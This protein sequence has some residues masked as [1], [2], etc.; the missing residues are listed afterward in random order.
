MKRA[1]I[2]GATGLV[3]RHL[4]EI[5]I[6]SSEYEKVTLLVRRPLDISS[7]KLEQIIYDYRNPADTEIPGD[8]FFCCLGTTIKKAGSPEVFREV[9]FNYITD[10][11][12]TACERGGE[13]FLFISAMGADKNSKIFYNRVKGETENAVKQIPLKSVFIFRP[14]LLAGKRKESRPGETLAGILMHIFKFFI[15]LKYRAIDAEKVAIAMYRYSLKDMVGV[16]II[17]SGLMQKM[18]S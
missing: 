7:S 5:L 4:T 2:A 17:E 3:G 18:S 1:V 15:P 9:D 16:N 13:K 8:S 12:R 10:F 11:A 6:N 14:S